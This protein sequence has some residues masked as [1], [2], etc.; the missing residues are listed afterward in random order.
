MD[1]KFFKACLTNEGR[2]QAAQRA[3]FGAYRARGEGLDAGYVKPKGTLN[4]NT[5]ARS[6]LIVGGIGH[7]KIMRLRQVPN[8]RWNGKAAAAMYPK[9]LAALQ[10]NVP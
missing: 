5:G 9:L 10:K 7:D 6:L 8:S 4:D 1:A 3:T 2:L